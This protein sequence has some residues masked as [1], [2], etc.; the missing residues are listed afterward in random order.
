M[1]K[2][3]AAQIKEKILSILK[4]KGPL[5]P[6]NIAN[7]MDMTM[8]F[9]S[10]FLSELF[11]DKKIKMSYMKVGSSPLYFLS[12]QEPQLERYSN[13][14]K[15]KEKDAF[16]LIKEKRILKDSEQE[17]AIRVALRSIRDFAIPLRKNNETYWR[18][19][20]IPESEFKE[21]QKSIEEHEYVE[22]KPKV[23]DTKEREISE[24]IIKDIKIE[25]IENLREEKERLEKIIKE[26]AG[27]MPEEKLEKKEKSEEKL[28]EII[29]EKPGKSE[30]KEEPKKVS[31]KTIQKK[32]VIS[33]KTLQKNNEKFFNQV[34][35]F[36]SKE[37]IEI[38][39]IE[40]FG[41]DEIFLRIKRE[42]DEKLLI[43]YN[44]KKIGENEIIKANKKALEL[45]LKYFILGMGE[46]GK[47]L[48]SLIE[49]IRNLEKIEKM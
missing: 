31:K 25:D 27:E 44:K 11:S 13:Y 35:E 34:K 14:L 41:K 16:M 48:S 45:N 10:A 33:K 7:E 26:K 32:K 4:F 17:P 42:G 2:Q 21:E 20:T 29:K 39:N 9:A 12:G 40:G 8:L 46:V 6:V 43:A 37:S 1:P 47:K 36:L 38:M 49:S 18:Y 5:L 3:D 23:F 30:V 24:K 19:F 28:E 22:P 15:S